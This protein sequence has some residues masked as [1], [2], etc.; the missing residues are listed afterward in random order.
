[1]P[2]V[3][4]ELLIEETFMGNILEQQSV[5]GTVPFQ[6]NNP[7]VFVVLLAF[8][9]CKQTANNYMFGE[10]VEWIRQRIFKQNAHKLAS[11]RCQVRVARRVRVRAAYTNTL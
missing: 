6:L 5:A 3:S 11:C 7:F 2:A 1:M 9:T 10:Q 4:I 8:Q